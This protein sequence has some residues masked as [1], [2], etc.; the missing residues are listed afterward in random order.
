MLKL[1]KM[2]SKKIK[3]PL[4]LRG[5]FPFCHS[6]ESGNPSHLSLRGAKQRSNLSGFSLIELMVA[7]A[8]L[9]FIVFGIFQAYSTA[10]MGMADARDRTVATNYAQEAMEDI[11][12]MDFEKI[13]TTTKSVINAN[14]KYRVDVNVSIESENLKKVSTVVSW[15]DRNGI[16]KTI[17]TSMLV[18]FIEIF[19]SDAAKIVLFTE[20]YSILN[21]PITAEYASTKLT[22][23]IKDLKGNTITDWGEDPNEGPISFSIISTDKFG[24]LSDDVVTPID[25]RAYTTFTSNES[26]SG[27]FGINVIEASVYLPDVE[28]IVTDTTIIKITDGPVKIILEP[29]PEMIKANTTNYSVI[30]ASLVDAAGVTLKKNGIFESREITFNVSG[31]GNPPTSTK[32]IPF[33]SGSNEEATVT[34]DLYSTGNPGLASVVATATDLESGKTDVLFLGTPVAISISANPNPMYL[35]DDH[36][37]ISVSLLDINGFITSPPTGTITINLDLTTD[38]N[39]VITDDSPLIF[40]SSETEVEVLTREFS[41]QNEAGTAI[42]TASGGAL[43]AASV[44]INVISAIIPEKI[45]ITASS[46]N[47]K[48]DGNESSTIKATIYDGS[49]KIVTN[50]IGNI[51][52]TITNNTSSA[53]FLTDSTVQVTNGFAEIEIVSSN[54]GNATV[55]IGNPDPDNLTIEPSEGIVIGFY[56]DPT[57]IELTANPTE[58]YGAETSVITAVIYDDDNPANIVTGIPITFTTSIGTFSNGDTEIT[59]TPA[60]GI[61]ITELSSSGAI[62]DAN[63]GV[64]AISGTIT[65]TASATVTFIEEIN[66]L[67]IDTP[68]YNSTD[69]TVTFNIR[70]TGKSIDIDEMKVS[71]VVSSASERLSEI[72]M[73]IPYDIGVEVDVYN[74]NVKSGESVDIVN[75]L[76]PIGKSTIKLTFIKNML[77]KTISVVFYPPTTGSYSITPF[78]VQ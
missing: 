26:I 67:L 61:A 2:L 58:I 53:I 38:T 62:G 57:S 7:A 44:T 37:T 32:T 65:L 50:Y 33:D 13:A 6:R 39:G 55:N 30:T 14:R 48:A 18:H 56:G 45:K 19:A 76:F 4:S 23:V 68:I 22:A 70:V 69:K 64:I 63:I 42:I 77:D 41:G 46:L 20:S 34:L 75:Q 74:G 12:N 71:W 54:S 11:K 24:T 47:V 49:G 51:V 5:L 25:G 31:E 35:D 73:K 3:F 72:S 17:D 36:S 60:D 15:K 8:I 29:N 28:E 43:P 16:T 1:N 9:A 21:S 10:F 66:L 59:I 52:F 78:L 27:N 40:T